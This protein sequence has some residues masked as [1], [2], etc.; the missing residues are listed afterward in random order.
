M[1]K[2]ELDIQQAN[3]YY[4]Y[5][6][7]KEM[8]ADL[9]SDGLNTGPKQMDVLIEST[10]MSLQRMK[11]WDKIFHISPMVESNLKKIEGSWTWYVITEGWCGDAS[12]IIPV[13]AKLASQNENIELKI[14][15]RDENH[16]IMNN[17]LTNGGMAIPILVAV[18]ND[19]GEAT[20]HFGP[21]PKEIQERVNEYK[22]EN[23]GFDKSVFN[24][25]LHLWYAKDKGLSTQHDV[26]QLVNTYMVAKSERLHRVG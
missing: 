18:N 21:R 7:F 15:L 17:Y 22:V 24:K 25:T 12:Q 3:K 26:L 19:T 8:V 6:E 13:I 10:K 23:P 9:F 4:S 2:L 16:G 11:K 1:N 20:P 14:L 5:L